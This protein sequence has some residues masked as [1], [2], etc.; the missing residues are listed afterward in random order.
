MTDTTTPPGTAV[1][2]RG[3]AAQRPAAPV[4][5]SRRTRARATAGSGRMAALLVSPTLLVLTIV[6]LYPTLMALH[7]SLYGPKG[8]DP[9]TGFIRTTEPF[10]GLHNYAGILGAA[11]QRF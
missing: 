10:V 2:E 7:E 8:L 9:S 1:R 3:S 11:G 6:V 5:P 4:R